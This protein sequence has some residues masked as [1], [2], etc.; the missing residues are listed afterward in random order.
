VS[1]EEG[2][3][4]GSET[5]HDAAIPF[6]HYFEGMMSLAPFRV[7]E[8][9]RNMQRILDAAPEPVIRLQPGWTYRIPLWE[10]VYH[11]C[12]VSYWYW[13]DYSNKILSVWG[14]RDLFNALYG[15]PPVYMFDGVFWNANRERFAASYKLAAATARA[16]EYASMT[17]FQI[18][19]ADRSVQRSKFSNGVQVTVNFGSSPWTLEDGSILLPRKSILTNSTISGQQN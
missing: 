17:N 3:I 1:T 12:V 9:G 19:A 4:T 6:L 18:L 13:G 15:T 11:D 8:A 16:T 2:L 5:G 7:P 14:L 10:L